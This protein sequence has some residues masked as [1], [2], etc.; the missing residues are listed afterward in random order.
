VPVAIPADGQ[1]GNDGQEAQ[2]EL[3]PGGMA[4]WFVILHYFS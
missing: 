4:Q 2:L 1:D 3:A